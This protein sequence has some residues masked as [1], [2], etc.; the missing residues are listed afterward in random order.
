ML[1]RSINLEDH[2][3]LE[4]VL[5]I[6]LENVE[7]LAP[8]DE[9]KLRRKAAIAERFDVIVADGQVAGFVVVYGPGST[10]WSPNFA[11]FKERYDDFVYLDRIALDPQFRRRGLASA[12]YEELESLA[13]P[14]GRMTLEAV[15]DNHGSLAFHGQRGYV[16]VGRFT[17]DGHDNVMMVKEL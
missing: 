15:D 14:H 12:A 7:V 4:T 11:W 10:Y 8:M 1:L 13:R 5:R 3:E 16:E 6:N 2:G 9:E 17:C